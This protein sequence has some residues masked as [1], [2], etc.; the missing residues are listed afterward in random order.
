MRCKARP[1]GSSEAS[2]GQLVCMSCV[3]AIYGRLIGYKLL[4]RF[5]IR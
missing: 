3:L 5:Q 4:Q 1:Q 2:E